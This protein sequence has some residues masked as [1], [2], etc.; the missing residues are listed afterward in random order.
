MQRTTGRGPLVSSQGTGFRN[1]D[2]LTKMVLRHFFYL[3]YYLFA[4]HLPRSNA[5]YAFLSGS[6]RYWICK[7]L[8]AECGRDVNIEQGA[9][10]GS[11]QH[12]RIGD[13]S[14]IGINCYMAMATIGKDVRM[15]PDVILQSGDHVFSER[16]KPIRLQ[17]YTEPRPIVIED[18]VYIGARVIILP[19]RKIGRGAVIGSGAV[20][21]KDVPE[22]AVVAGNPARI[23]KYRGAPREC[24]G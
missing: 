6:I 1:C 4:R 5:S 2:I 16:D 18:D 22:Y 9:W 24:E 15:G 21:T 14:G 19:G 3:L 10:F 23:V 20:V 17:G 13:N 12:V 11:G 8:F 7:H